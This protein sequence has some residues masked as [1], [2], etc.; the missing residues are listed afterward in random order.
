MNIVVADNI[1]NISSV[2]EIIDIGKRE[3]DLEIVSIGIQGIEGAKGDKGDKGD[4]GS[5]ED[6][7]LREQV[8]NTDTNYTNIFIGALL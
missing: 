3:I 2:N 8:G 7:V 1:L 6:T 4:T 5:G